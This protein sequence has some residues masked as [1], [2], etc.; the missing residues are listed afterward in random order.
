MVRCGELF[1]ECIRRGLPQNQT[2]GV[3]N[4]GRTLTVSRERYYVGTGR[5]R[6]GRY[7]VSCPIHGEF[8]VDS[9]IWDTCVANDRRAARIILNNDETREIEGRIRELI[10]QNVSE[11]DILSEITLRLQQMRPNQRERNIV[12]F[13]RGIIGDIRNDI[14]REQRER[15]DIMCP[16]CGEKR[17][18]H[19]TNTQDNTEFYFCD[20]PRCDAHRMRL[21]PRQAKEGARVFYDRQER[22]LRQQLNAGNMTPDTYSCLLY[23]SPS[24]RDL[25]TSRMPSSA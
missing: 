4:C 23:T 9:D 8:T 3:Q 6:R 21:S 16:E 19:V 20:N 18:M 14:G 2:S 1:N 11:N 17:L 13:A 22:N 25:S 15:S 10:N 24:P 5:N 7:D 12:R